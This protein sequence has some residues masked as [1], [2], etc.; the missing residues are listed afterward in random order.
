M[1]RKGKYARKS[2]YSLIGAMTCMF[3]ILF[4]KNIASFAEQ[5]NKVDPEL[6]DELVGRY[7][8][9][10]QGQK[11]VFAF[12]TEEG[13]LMGAPAGEN[14]S[15]LKPVEGKDMTFVGYSP[16]GTEHFFKFVRDEEGKVAKCVL[17]IPTMGL[18]AD[19]FKMEK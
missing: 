4:M 18:V 5:E 13:K 6:L 8:F 11:G 17:S 1:M 3:F 2:K 16:D 9:E 15:V 10:I 14:P 7:E 19:M 12:I